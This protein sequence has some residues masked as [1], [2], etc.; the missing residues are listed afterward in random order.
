MEAHCRILQTNFSR[1]RTMRKVVAFSTVIPRKSG[2][3]FGAYRS[4]TQG[5]L[6]S[7]G[8]GLDLTLSSCTG[9][10]GHFCEPNNQKL[11]E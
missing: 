4:P 5:S 6:F 10:F 11:F 2:L 1:V 8:M 7:C 9:R 3:T